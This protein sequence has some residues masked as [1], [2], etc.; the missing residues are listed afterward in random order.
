MTCT[1]V[2]VR[3]PRCQRTLLLLWTA[4]R[5]RIN[6]QLCRKPLSSGGKTGGRFWQR[7]RRRGSSQFLVC[8]CCQQCF[9]EDC[10]SRRGISTEEGPKDG[11]WYHSN[12][13]RECFATLKQQVRARVRALLASTAGWSCTTRS[14]GA[15]ASAGHAPLALCCNASRC[16]AAAAA[17]PQAAS[18]A[19]PLPDGRSWQLVD[20]EPR[21]P[22]SLGGARALAAL[23]QQLGDVLE[24]LLPAYGP[25]VAQQLVDTTNGYAVLLRSQGQRPVTAGLLD[26]YGQVGGGLRVRRSAVLL[27][28]AS[29][30]CGACVGACCA[31]GADC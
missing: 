10:C 13:C 6:C 26:V 9:H 29:V 1:A 11:R 8:D 12:S 16:C 27:A 30:Q 17:E 14:S 7:G 25:G 19:A 24:V 28:R 20:C 22:R 3:L 2:R 31:L 18:G 21:N 15:R 23:K 5:A 4:R